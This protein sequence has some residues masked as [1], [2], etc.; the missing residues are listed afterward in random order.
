MK[1]Y[2]TIIATVAL[3]LV[4]SAA[5]SKAV[6]VTLNPGDAA[7]IGSTSYTPGGTLIAQLVSPYT[8]LSGDVG[9][10]TTQVFQND[11]NNTLGGLTFVYTENL[12]AGFVGTIAVDGFNGTVT[13]GCQ[14]L[15]A[16]ATCTFAPATVTPT[17]AKTSTT[18]TI[19]ASQ[20]AS[21]RWPF[22]GGSILVCSLLACIIRRR[23]HFSSLAIIVSVT[24]LIGLSGCVSPSHAKTTTTSITV[25][26]SAGSVQRTTTVTLQIQ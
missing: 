4:C 25:T 18:M 24:A 8:T 3:G 26:A 13:F 19:A 6:L 22:E 12:T 9:T 16:G 7:N 23:K 21:L 1:N 10:F 14:G 2:K 11:P 20:T 5:T 17:A 15:P